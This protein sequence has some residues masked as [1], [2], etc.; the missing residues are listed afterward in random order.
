MMDRD[1]LILSDKHA[2]KTV[3]ELFYTTNL[4]LGQTERV[5]YS[6]WNWLGD[7]G[8]FFGVIWALGS[9]TSLIVSKYTLA[10]LLTNGFLKTKF[11][12]RLVDLMPCRNKI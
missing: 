9:Y 1:T 10:H 5:V 8:G 12:I 2:Q 4:N 3:L 6:F 7:V 11:D